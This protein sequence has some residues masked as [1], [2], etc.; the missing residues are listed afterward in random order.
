[1][2]SKTTSN[3]ILHDKMIKQFLWDGKKPRIRLDQLCESRKR[4]GLS[5]P[6]IKY[7]SVSFEMS[8]LKEH[9][10]KAEA[11]LDWVLIEQELTFPFKPR[12][13]LTQ[14]NKNEK[15]KFNSPILGHLKMVWQEVHKRSKGHQDN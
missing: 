15:N 13:A 7:Y 9:W 5:L 14:T 4:G 12:E 8:R 10:N 3:K 1:M 6:N 11:D 2:H